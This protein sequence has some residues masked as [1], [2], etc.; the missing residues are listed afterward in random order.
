[1]WFLHDE[2]PDL[3]KKTL[4]MRNTKRFLDRQRLCFQVIKN[5][6]DKHQGLKRRTTWLSAEQMAN[7]FWD[8]RIWVTFAILKQFRVRIFKVFSQLV[9][10]R[11]QTTDDVHRRLRCS[12]QNA[13]YLFREH[14]E[15]QPWADPLPAD[16]E[17]A[18]SLSIFHT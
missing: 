13:I 1:M 15:K 12:H 9:K 6:D 18:L 11:P 7:I 14:P 5:N 17:A 10:V 4:S 8:S 16:R 3:A 2:G